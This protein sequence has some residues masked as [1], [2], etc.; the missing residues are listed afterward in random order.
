MTAIFRSKMS[1][2][3][4]ATVLLISGWLGGKASQRQDA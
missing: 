3:V 2:I 1:F 4:L